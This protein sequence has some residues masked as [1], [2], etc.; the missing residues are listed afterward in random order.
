M[1]MFNKTCIGY[2]HLKAK[3]S[4]EDYS[5]SFSEKNKYIIAVADGHGGKIYIRSNKGSKFACKAAIDVLNAYSSNIQNDNFNKLKLDLLCKFNEYVYNDLNKNPLLTKEMLELSDKEKEKLIKDPLIAY[6]TTLHAVMKMDDSL[7]C[8]SIGDGKVLMVKNDN[9]L[10]P[11]D[12]YDDENIANITTSLSLENAYNFIHVK[13]MKIN[14]ICGVFCMTDGVTT[15]YQNYDN[16]NKSLIIPL[17]KGF[18][19]N[20]IIQAKK[21]EKFIYDLGMKTGCGDDVSLA[22]FYLKEG[23]YKWN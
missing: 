4:C 10:D 14:N 9:I 19:K 1:L 6:G 16:L 11:F 22:I 20:P 13:K 8:L 5:I 18:E 23:V 12:E 3:T 2:N 15:P 21:I 7:I 17:A